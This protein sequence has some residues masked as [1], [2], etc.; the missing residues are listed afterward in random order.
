ML[1][2][3]VIYRD[4]AQFNLPGTEYL[5]YFLFRGFGVRLWL[6]PLALLVTET[7]I[8]LLVYSLSRVVLRGTAALLPAVAILVVCQ[9]N[10]IDGTHHWYST[11]LVLLAIRVIARVRNPVSLAIAGGLLGLATLFTSSRGVFVAIGVSLFLVWELRSRRS[12]SRAIAAL[13]VPLTAIVALALLYLASVAGPKALFESVIVFPLSYYRA[14]NGNSASVFLSVWRDALP[15]GPH[16]LPPIAVWLVLNVAVPMALVGFVA[17][18]LLQKAAHPGGS[19]PNRALILYAFAA[20]F[21]LLAVTSAPSTPRLFCTG[22][23]VFIMG[24]ATLQELGARRL[25]GSVLAAA[26]VIG[27]AEIAIA[28]TRPVQRLDGPLGAAAFRPRDQYED[29]AWFAS[30][31]HPGDRLFGSPPLNFVLNL[32]NPAGIQWVEADAYTRPEQVRDL[33][34]ALSREPTRFIVWHE[35]SPG[36]LRPGDSLQPFRAYLKEH[37]RPVQRFAD[38]AEV[39]IDDVM[40]TPRL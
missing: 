33:L 28:V 7:A 30:H 31:A 27:L 6:E 13:L 25:I 29:F 11:L 5:Y 15:L 14:G 23:F 8:T 26:C 18:C 3:E 10:M 40:E 20:F 22:C 34:I 24:T 37:Y 17:R 16:S 39:W 4:L 21:A 35:E 1:H 12:A 19:Q 9:R 38:G 2:G 32:S 36:S